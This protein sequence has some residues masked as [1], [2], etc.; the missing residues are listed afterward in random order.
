MLNRFGT[1][2]PVY[3]LSGSIP[4]HKVLRPIDNVCSAASAVSASGP[5][6]FGL[7]W[8]RDYLTSLKRR[9]TDGRR[10]FNQLERRPR[11]FWAHFSACV[12]AW[13]RQGTVIHQGV[14]NLEWGQRSAS[15][16]GTQPD[17]I[18]IFVNYI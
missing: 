3:V 12:T 5:R 13:G 8:H 11:G 16:S 6:M 17:I 15:I 10:W 2:H 1:Y 14:I 7:G 4:I 18:L 9:R